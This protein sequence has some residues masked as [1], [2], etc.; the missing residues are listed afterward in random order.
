MG[1]KDGTA[2]DGL[3]PSSLGNYPSSPFLY[4]LA[5]FL[6]KR[7]FTWVAVSF[8]NVCVVDLQLNEAC[9]WNTNFLSLHVLLDFSLQTF[10]P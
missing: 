6:L 7:S 3:G 2:Q 10:K 9:G 4:Y 8:V 1:R 5:L